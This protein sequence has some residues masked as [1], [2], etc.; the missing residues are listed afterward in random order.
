M[1]E[2]GRGRKGEIKEK[3]EKDR[4][5][6]HKERE[7]TKRQ[8]QRVCESDRERGRKK[9]RDIHV[10]TFYYTS[11]FLLPR[12]LPH[13]NSFIASGRVQWTGSLITASSDG[14]RAPTILPLLERLFSEEDG[15]FTSSVLPSAEVTES[16]LLD[17]EEEEKETE[18]RTSKNW[19]EIKKEMKK[20][21]CTYCTTK[22]SKYIIFVCTCIL[23]Y[24]TF[25]QVSNTLRSL[26]VHI[27]E[28]L[29]S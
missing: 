10:H 11:A 2:R 29:H 23:N 3:T 19:R 1:K 9:G 12:L 5:K 28:A 8:R 7:E 21:I 4:E 13:G 22:Y 25:S 26:H 27:N 6:R 14:N 20:C 17:S 24:F 15:D 16:S 18:D